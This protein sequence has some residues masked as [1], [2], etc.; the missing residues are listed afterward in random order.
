MYQILIRRALRKLSPRFQCTFHPILHYICI[1][2]I[3]QHRISLGYFGIVHLV[4]R[5]AQIARKVSYLGCNKILPIHS[6][7]S[8]PRSCYVHGCKLAVINVGKWKCLRMS[9]QM[10]NWTQFQQKVQHHMHMMICQWLVL[11]IFCRS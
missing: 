7:D 8:S 2:T 6:V 5:S 9:D 10:W 1:R 3:L 11:T 4:K